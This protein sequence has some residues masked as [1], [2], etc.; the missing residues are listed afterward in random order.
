MERRGRGKEKRPW[1]VEE[2]NQ[3]Q[4]KKKEVLNFLFPVSILKLNK[5]D[6]DEVLKDQE[7]V[8]KI[9]TK[10]KKNSVK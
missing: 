7:K 4:N 2:K 8:S 3:K 5:A 6:G 1:R 9:D 10:K